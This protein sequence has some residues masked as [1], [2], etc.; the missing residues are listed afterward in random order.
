M[1]NEIYVCQK[2]RCSLYLKLVW[3]LSLI[4]KVGIP[5]QGVKENKPFDTLGNI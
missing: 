2:L 5:A 1:G 4:L 3:K